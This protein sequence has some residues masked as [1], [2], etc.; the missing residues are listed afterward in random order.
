MSLAPAKS[1]GLLETLRLYAPGI[2][3]GL[4]TGSKKQADRQILFATAPALANRLDIVEAADLLLIDEADQAYVRD[5]TKQY[6]AILK[7]A[8]RYAGV[9]GTPFVLEKGRTVPIFG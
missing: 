1:D 2:L 3:G 6:S 5:D 9:T 4:Y 8:R 7:V